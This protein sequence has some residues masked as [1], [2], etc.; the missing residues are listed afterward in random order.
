MDHFFS[1][2]TLLIRDVWG[3][4]LKVLQNERKWGSEERERESNFKNRHKRKKSL[5][6][7]HYRSWNEKINP[8]C[9]S[10]N[11]SPSPELFMSE[12]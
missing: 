12:P 10:F 8:L 3:F 2:G 6:K 9:V 1:A 4:S 5:N 11:F 7:I